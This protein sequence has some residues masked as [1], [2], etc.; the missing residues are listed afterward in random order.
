MRESSQDHK[1]RQSHHEIL[2]IAKF[3]RKHGFP[4]EAV[5]G[6]IVSKSMKPPIVTYGPDGEPKVDQTEWEKEFAA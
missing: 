4:V 6:W 2:T 3:A 5:M 1:K